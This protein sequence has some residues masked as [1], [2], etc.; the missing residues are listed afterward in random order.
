MKPRTDA[1]GY[2]PNMFPDSRL[3]DVMKWYKD[4]YN[5]DLEQFKKEF[6]VEEFWRFF[7]DGCLQKEE[8]WQGFEKREPGYLEAMFFA[9]TLMFDLS[10][11]LTI[12]YIRKLHELAMTGVV[13][14]NYHKKN[15]NVGF[16]EVPNNSIVFGVLSKDENSNV[17]NATQAGIAEFLTRNKT[18]DSGQHIAVDMDEKS[19]QRRYYLSWD[20]INELVKN[21]KNINSIYEKND[22]IF[23]ILLKYSSEQLKKH[24]AEIDNLFLESHYEFI[25]E[26]INSDG[27]PE[28]VAK[29][30]YVQ[31]SKKHKNFNFYVRSHQLEEDEGILEDQIDNYILEYELN[32]KNANPMIKLKA[33]ISLIQQCEQLHP[34][35]DGNGRTFCMLLLNHFLLKNGFPMVILDDS[36]RFDLFSEAELLNEI[37]NGMQN[38]V[39]LLQKKKLYDV[40]TL[41][42]LNAMGVQSSEYR[43]FNDLMLEMTEQMKE[44]SYVPR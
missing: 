14:T 35:G 21:C 4:T 28:Q 17:Y 39:E 3:A 15:I 12:E 24:I 10:Q 20:C 32:V 25:N 33:I 6:P 1:G 7:V 27:S 38:T 43:Y 22:L 34:F 42:V 30:I 18:N 5:G 37:I 29:C 11:P 13:N 8:N 44:P 26:I 9:S 23:S 40:D 36:N 41:D 2:K 16:R 19:L 31:M